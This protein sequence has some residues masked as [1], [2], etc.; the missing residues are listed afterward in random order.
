M[1]TPTKT[2]NLDKGVIQIT[3]TDCE[4]PYYTIDYTT[5]SGK[6]GIIRNTFSDS[7]SELNKMTEQLIADLNATIETDGTYTENTENPDTYV[8]S[9]IWTHD[10]IAHDLKEHGY[11]ATKTNIKAVL[12]EIRPSELESAMIMAG[13]DYIYAAREK[14]EKRNKIMK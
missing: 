11:P 10:D 14:A 12:S 5:K 6:P 8:A 3:H 1:A 2:I 4:K 7:E 9:C 13:W